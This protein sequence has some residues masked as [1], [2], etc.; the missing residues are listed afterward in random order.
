M[1]ERHIGSGVLLRALQDN[2]S[3]RRTANMALVKV[4][5]NALA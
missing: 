3:A 1:I 4:P 5:L 2:V